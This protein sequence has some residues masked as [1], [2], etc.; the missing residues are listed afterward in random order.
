MLY[1]KQ[2]IAHFILFWISLMRLKTRA[3]VLLSIII[4]LQIIVSVQAQDCPCVKT[5]II[6]TNSNRHFVHNNNVV[7]M[8]DTTIIQGSYLLL[9]TQHCVGKASWFTKG[10]END[11]SDLVISPPTSE[12]YIV[13]STLKGCPD[14]YDTVKITVLN[15]YSGAENEISIYPNPA[16]ATIEVRAGSQRINSIEVI[17]N[18]GRIVITQMG[19]TQDTFQIINLSKVPSGIYY[20]KVTADRFLHVKKIIKD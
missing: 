3:H 6:G 5:K 12:E 17:D 15:F 18:Y 4:L 13:K 7:A 11:L 10:S 16:K 19:L 14:V 9:R 8:N 1:K 2:S 20:V